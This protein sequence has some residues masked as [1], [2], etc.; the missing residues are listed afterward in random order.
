[1]E[2]FEQ[3]FKKAYTKIKECKNVL[4]VTHQH[5]DGD[6]LSS[7]SAMSILLDKLSKKYTL[8]CIDSPPSFFSFLPN[9]EKII[10]NTDFNFE[11]FDLIIV[12]DCGCAERSGIAS[13]LKKRRTNQYIIEFDHHPK[14]DNYSNLEI[15]MSDKSSTSEII[16]YFF[17]ANSLIINKETANC[18][19]TGILTDTANFLHPSAN[20][21]TLRISS[22]M[23]SYGASLPKI[24]KKT[25]Q[26]KRL[27]SMKTLGKVLDNLQI[28]KNYNI[29]YSVLT[30]E[31]VIDLKK[32]FKNE[33]DI[34]DLINNFLS[35]VKDVRAVMFLREEIYGKIKGS[36]RT[37]YQKTEV[38][39]LARL[40][41][42][43]GHPRACGFEV[44][45]HIEKNEK[46]WRVV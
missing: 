24:T 1:M 40:L 45:G 13:R 38:V 35:N 8:F 29:A 41:G 25:Q 2:D 11:K 43:G 31:E 6:A 33:D 17:K 34:F 46:G 14:T 7:I 27:S 16:Y 12:L 18:I 5:P 10:K 23:L 37:N 20:I 9:I 28:N 3:K 42:G 15:R 4:V 22:S 21:E 30:L 32:E 39:S 36:L 26:N 19:L 44:D